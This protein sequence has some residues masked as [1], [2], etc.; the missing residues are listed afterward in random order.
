MKK[1]LVLLFLLACILLPGCKPKSNISL[2]PDDHL[3]TKADL[4]PYI[5]NLMQRV[6]AL[7]A[8][9]AGPWVQYQ[10]NSQWVAIDPNSQSYQS[11][12][13]P[14]GVLLVST[15]SVTP[16]LDGYKVKVAIGN[17][18]NVTFVGFQLAYWCVVP[19]TITFEEETQGFAKTDEFGGVTV[20]PSRTG[21]SSGFTPPPLSSKGSVSSSLGPR[22]RLPDFASLRAVNTEDRTETLYPGS[23]NEIEF[24]VAPATADDIRHLRMSIELNEV[25]LNSAASN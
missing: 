23:W 2:V 1:L 24:T 16:Y 18:Y 25:R 4:R 12:W 11:L 7:E 22:P 17:P 6:S 13:T 8:N 15:K 5:T 3:V 21:T 19:K 14:F 20:S 10:R 9:N